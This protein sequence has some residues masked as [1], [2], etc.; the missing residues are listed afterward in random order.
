MVASIVVAALLVVML[1]GLIYGRFGPDLVV[2][3]TVAGLL[4]A[5]F[6]IPTGWLDGRTILDPAD[7]L[8]GFSSQ[9]LATVALLY[10]VSA[11]VRETGAMTLITTRLLGNPKTALQAQARLVLPVAVSSAFINNTPIVTMFLPVLSSLAKRT[12]IPA[13]KLFMP[14]S[15]A[16]ILGGLCTLIGTSTNLVI[17][18]LI[19]THNAD[20]PD[21]PQLQD[22]GMFTLAAIGVPIA[23]VGVAYVLLFGRRL[24][25]GSRSPDDPAQLE[26]RDY[27]TAMRV[28]P[29]SSLV[30]KSIAQAE[31]RNL[32]GL[33][34]S[35]IDRED[36]TILAV[37]PDVKLMGDDILVFVGRLESVV[38]LQKIKGLA[39]ATGG[40]T[41]DAYRP[42]LQLIE[43]VI[44]QRSPL[45]N[46]TIREAGIRTRY[47]AVVVGVHRQGHQEGG[48]IGDIRLRA[49]DTLLLEAAP[50]F[51]QRFR[52]ST[53]FYLVNQLDGAAAPRH[54]RAGLALGILTALVLS[55]SI[56]NV[57]VVIAALTAAL[58]LVLTRCCTGGQARRSIDWQVLIVI[59]GAFALGR[60]MENSGLAR[61]LADNAVAW[62][63]PVGSWAV[64][65]VIYA[66]T[67]IFTA[68]IN[69]N[70]AA[71]LMF[72]VALEASRI[73]G[74]DFMPIAVCLAVAATAEFSTPIGYQ[75]NLIV[76]GPGGY[77]WSDYT[78]FGL[79]LTILCGVICVALAPILYT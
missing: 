7:A 9:G 5:D 17:D 38:D 48:K 56:F 1:G 32:P 26:T 53:D 3:G 61:L 6:V 10:V 68:T 22:F 50:N 70:A 51:A 60:A 13:G 30:G 59:G 18:G 41:H 40:D 43:A 39:P 37:D 77:R 19:E 33:Y 46:R 75:T 69:N 55:I 74:I 36:A 4:V 72:P 71:V 29:G 27:Y 57:P 20:F 54:E 42:K 64:L 58:A 14:L 12:G 79:P 78:K 47:G 52:E 44:S 11:A 21:Q 23:L 49:G 63:S 62:A 25:P 35:R 65:A 2:L 16:A 24:L 66:L 8:T 73:T 28:M 76:W 45:I 67:T 15:Y 34:L 31:L